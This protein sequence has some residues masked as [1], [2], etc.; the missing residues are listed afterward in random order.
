MRKMSSTLTFGAALAVVMIL[1]A[2]DVSGLPANEKSTDGGQNAISR[3]LEGSW[4]VDLTI[5]DCVSS[6]AIETAPLMNS[7]MPGGVVI[8]TPGVSP[9]AV[10]NGHGVWEHAGGQRFT[11][12]VVTFVFAPNGI[13][14][15]ATRG[16]RLIEL[17]E[18]SNQ[19]TTTDTFVLRD[20]HGNVIG[21][22]CATG[23]GRRIE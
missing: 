3:R 22:R 16:S 14:V 23:P 10:S 17:S 11:A 8:S 5:R 15:G 7:F 9:L 18:D 19:F 13:L 12:T 20:V 2:G 4:I 21:S 1:V 6:A